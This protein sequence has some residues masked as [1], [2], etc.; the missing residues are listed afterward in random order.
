MEKRVG[1]WIRYSVLYRK[2]QTTFALASLGHYFAVVRER[3]VLGS[4]LRI[5]NWAGEAKRVEKE[6]WF[7]LPFRACSSNGGADEGCWYPRHGY[8]LPSYLCSAS[9]VLVSRL[10]L[11]FCFSGF[12]G[13]SFV[14]VLF[15]FFYFFMLVMMGGFWRRLWLIWWVKFEG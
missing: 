7:D 14:V 2:E 12:C 1:R 5:L 13:T 15:V 11:F 10:F 6:L 3:E 4:R 9:S 8:L